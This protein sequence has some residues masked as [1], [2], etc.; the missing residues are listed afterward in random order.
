MTEPDAAAMAA[1]VE[2]SG[3]ILDG[4]ITTREALSRIR[5]DPA[6]LAGVSV[7]VL[8]EASWVAAKESRTVGCSIAGLLHEWTV[9]HAYGDP[10][11]VFASGRAFVQAATE[12]LMVADDHDLYRRAHEAADRM[13]DAARPAAAA[14][15]HLVAG[16]LHLAPYALESALDPREYTLGREL[17]R[18]R[19]IWSL[20]R[21]WATGQPADTEI[22]ELMPEPGVGLGRAV[23]HLATAAEGTAGVAK[24]EALTHL[25]FAAYSRH[26]AD[27]GGSLADVDRWCDKAV[28]L[29]PPDGE[30]LACGRLLWLYVIRGRARSVALL[31]SA[32]EPLRLVLLP[33][34]RRVDRPILLPRLDP[35]ADGRIRTV[36][37]GVTFLRLL[38][39]VGLADAAREI[40]QTVWLLTALDPDLQAQRMFLDRA[41]AHCLP[42]DPAGCRERL[43]G[44]V[45]TPVSERG[46]SLAAVAADRIHALVCG[47]GAESPHP[48]S[49]EAAAEAARWS[50]EPALSRIVVMV[51][52]HRIRAMLTEA[53][54]EQD[55]WTILLLVRAVTTLT[56]S[57]NH[58]LAMLA[59][60]RLVSAVADLSIDWI[61]GIDASSMFPALVAM[62]RTALASL[63][64]AGGRAAV[65]SLK[66]LL[67][68]WS[69]LRTA[70]GAVSVAQ[71]IILL[72]GQALAGALARPGPTRPD[73][74][75]LRVLA[76]LVPRKDIVLDG[77][78]YPWD[79][80][81]LLHLDPEA[82]IGTFLHDAEQE[83]GSTETQ[84]LANLKR[85]AQRMDNARL[86]AHAAAAPFRPLPE[87]QKAL[88]ADAV[89]L[90]L[91]CGA[92][93]TSVAAVHVT[94]MDKDRMAEL[95]VAG[96][97]ATRF[98]ESRTQT[99]WSTPAETGFESTRI[100]GSWLGPTIARMR[101]ELLQDPLHR[102]ITRAGEYELAEFVRFLSGKVLALLA[103]FADAGRTRL[104]VWPNEALYFLPLHLLP[105]RGGVLADHFIVT[106]LPS[107]ECLFRMP[108]AASASQSM[109]AIASAAG[110]L[111]DGLPEEPSLHEQ[112][113]RVAGL[114]GGRAL[115]GPDATPAAALEALGTSRY[116]HL[117]AHGTQDVDAPLFARLYLAGGSLHAHQ[118]LERDLRRTEL[119][120]L[121]A[122]ESALL[123]YDFFDNLHGLAPAFLR[124]GAAAVVGALW[125]VAPEVAA[126]FFT[127]LY[128]RLADGATRVDAF[129]HAQVHARARHSNHRDWGAFTYFG[130]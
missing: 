11:A 130:A 70:S 79:I 34:G 15:G 37:T 107:V 128:A 64:E 83:R 50:G 38:A 94:M 113:E 21:G 108:P 76:R 121:S 53:D 56:Q 93:G 74:E 77:P 78:H 91:L 10:A 115:T 99:I 57:G 20:P 119:V 17:R 40:V 3:M 42:D 123:R 59:L 67:G 33:S 88:P 24:G 63:P 68:R 58:D 82:V 2:L 65:Y 22:E 14:T 28:T 103:E 84:R 32:A 85:Q 27:G 86:M 41:A 62:V 80:R 4:V 102:D 60:D 97:D 122:C 23:R 29:L 31:R 48:A 47:S 12:V 19:E 114:F 104:V 124:A 129:R 45:P 66:M 8:A 106:V 55:E 92:F 112:A 35:A 39:E 111:P 44:A 9:R 96:P 30:P 101:R 118:I 54:G 120:T 95:P 26:L 5:R 81:S 18:L 87:V 6:L 36:L 73:R 100:I 52:N 1:L 105:F 98:N 90:N 127:E 109:C 13:I 72:K 7:P 49:L 89:L 46:L 110:G 71:F 16:M 125:P 69:A 25:A 117:A 51:T 75:M 126:T 43:L 116:L 61:A